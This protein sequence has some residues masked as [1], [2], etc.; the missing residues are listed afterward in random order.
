MT[1]NEYHLGLKKAYEIFLFV[2]ETI[3]KGIF[4]IMTSFMN[5]ELSSW[6]Q[7]I[8]NS[9]TPQGTFL[10]LGCGGGRAIS[11]LQKFGINV[12]GI[13]INPY[14]I[15]HCLD[16]GI[17]A[18]EAD[19]FG[20]IPEAFESS[21]DFVGIGFNTLFNFNPK[22]RTKWVQ[23][24]CKSLKPG[25]LLMLS[26]YSD[27]KYIDVY[28]Q[29]RIDWYEYT[30]RAPEGYKHIIYE[31]NGERGI[32]LLAPDGTVKLQSPWNKKEVVIKEA[33]TWEGF[34]VQDTMLFPCKIGQ[35]LVLEKI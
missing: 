35:I 33:R 28:N 6:E 5:E 11:R 31:E 18:T 23:F 13:D 22:D 1:D 3:D 14:L 27:N 16:R 30:N 25:G 26:F 17:N 7:V 29:E 2:E 21:A 10:E 34:K 20:P 8:K 12:T 24:A 9:Q 4:P 32:K 19:I 15:Q